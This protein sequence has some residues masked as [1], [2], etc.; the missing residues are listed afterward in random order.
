MNGHYHRL[1]VVSSHNMTININEL[2][3][4]QDTNTPAPRRPHYY[5]GPSNVS[6]A[7]TSADMNAGTAH[8]AYPLGRSASSPSLALMNAHRFPAKRQGSYARHSILQGNRSTPDLPGIRVEA[9][10]AEPNATDL[11]QEDRGEGP[12]CLPTP[13]P[14]SHSAAFP[15]SRA[16]LDEQPGKFIMLYVILV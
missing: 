10:K 14:M 2:T 8:Q 16:S 11:A 3:S 15:S 4:V 13:T 6:W 5:S 1:L 9:T 7:S 12:S